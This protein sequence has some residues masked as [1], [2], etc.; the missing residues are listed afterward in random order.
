MVNWCLCSGAS[1]SIYVASKNKENY[2]G[3]KLEQLSQTQ[4]CYAINV[5]PTTHVMLV[6]K[7][8]DFIGFPNERDFIKIGVDFIYENFRLRCA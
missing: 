4:Q 6:F 5:R 3:E 7:L 8:R 2:R 1:G